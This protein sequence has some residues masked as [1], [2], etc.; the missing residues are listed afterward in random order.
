MNKINDPSLFATKQIKIY[1]FVTKHYLLNQDL[2]D[3]YSNSRIS[4]S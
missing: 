2:H 1:F 3:C 4:L